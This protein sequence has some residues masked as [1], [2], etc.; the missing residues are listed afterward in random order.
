MLQNLLKT[1][2]K[3]LQN[4]RRKTWNYKT[5]SRKTSWKIVMKMLQNVA[6]TENCYKK[7]S[8]NCRKTPNLLQKLSQ[9]MFKN[10]SKIV[11]KILQNLAK[12]IKNYRNT[13]VKLTWNYNVTKTYSKIHAKLSRKCYKTSR[14]TTYLRIASI[15]VVMWMMTSQGGFDHSITCQ[16]CHQKI[17]I[18]IL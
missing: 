12:T 8:E 9:N 3:I 13:S 16:K 17:N 11:T 10:F 5:K 4:F 15:G 18:T 7:S 6:K 14:K 2:T 1:E